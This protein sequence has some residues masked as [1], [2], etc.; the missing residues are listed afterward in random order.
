MEIR[1]PVA[2]GRFYEAEPET[3]R[4][5]IKDSFSHEF[6]PG[7]AK[8]QEVK[9]ALVPHAGY[10]FSGPC[11]AHSYRAIGEKPD[12][13]VILGP[14]HT[15]RG[16]DIATSTGFWETPL[17][18]C[19]IDNGFASS[20]GIPA[21]QEA[22]RFEHSIEVQLPFLQY[23]FRDFKFVPIC[24]RDCDA[25]GVAEKIINSTGDKK[26]VLLAS[27]DMTHYGL[28]YSYMPFT[29]N[30][31]E[32]MYAMDK[33][34]LGYITSIDP[35]GFSEHVQSNHLTV[36]G[37]QS[38]AIMLEWSKMLGFRHGK[39]L[40]YYTS[41]DIIKDYGSAVGYASVVIT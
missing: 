24:V 40:K 3:L 38:I 17:G 23:L 30:A 37:W 15:G 32:N 1:A 34:T 12:I 26:I 9:A 20:L 6:G 21:N 5:S 16:P 25:K 35:A 27:S 10:M 14:N 28:A 4:R 7:G 11:A 33:E 31:K 36:C 19:R 29:D 8:P 18:R 2:A 39:L 22:H 13:F 41:G